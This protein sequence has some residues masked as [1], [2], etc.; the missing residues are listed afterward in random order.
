MSDEYVRDLIMD[1]LDGPEILR[2]GPDR[3]SP[4]PLRPRGLAA[5]GCGLASGLVGTLAA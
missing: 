5:L 4:I 1:S 3:P 2:I